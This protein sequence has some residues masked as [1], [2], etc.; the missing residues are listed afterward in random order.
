MVSLQGRIA[1]RPPMEGGGLMLTLVPERFISVSPGETCGPRVVKAELKDTYWKLTRLG[2]Q[3]V[4]PTIQ[5]RE[6]HLVLSSEENRVSGFSGCNSLS[7]SY[8]LNGDSI[9]FSP[10]AS[11]MM[12]CADG[13]DVERAFFA[14][15]ERVR[16]WR[17]LGRNL[18]FLDAE[19]ELA[20]R[21]EARLKE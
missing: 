2:D 19:G 11:T 5:E 15:L 7:G 1:Q 18:D 13:A 6:P 16:T 4:L 14:A 21:F 10:M 12:A 20:A 3:P 8:T 17:L 9:G